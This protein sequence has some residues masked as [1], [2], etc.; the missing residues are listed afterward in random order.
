MYAIHAKHICKTSKVGATI[1]ELSA[2]KD[3]SHLSTSCN[4]S[5]AAILKKGGETVTSLFREF[6]PHRLL[7]KNGS[8]AASYLMYLSHITPRFQPALLQ[9]DD[10]LGHMVHPLA[11]YVAAPFLA[12]E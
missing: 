6:K 11:D 3:M 7:P 4:S 5:S 2:T 1:T 8:P 10:I 12:E 9:M